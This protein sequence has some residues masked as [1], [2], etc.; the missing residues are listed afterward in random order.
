MKWTEQQLALLRRLH[1]EDASL[2]RASVI[3][4]KSPTWLRAR[5]REL[6]IPFR[7]VRERKNIQREKEEVA[8]KKEELEPVPREL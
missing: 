1:R 3:L 5:A 4:K 7:S 6:G 8:R 2:A